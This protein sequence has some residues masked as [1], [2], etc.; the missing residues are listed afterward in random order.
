MQYSLFGRTGLTVSRL[1]LGT[2]TFGKQ[3]DEA[4]SFRIFDMAAEAGVNLIDTADMYP[5][6]VGFAERGRSEEFTGRWLKGKR[7]RFILATKAGG[8]MGPLAWDQGTSRKH[9]L[10]AVD[11][12]LRR[13]DVDYI[14]LYQLHM[15]DVAT[16]PDETIEA[17]DTIVRSGKARYVG[18][19]NF[20]AYRLARALGRQE[21]LRLARYV[22]VQPRYNLLFREIER[23]LLPLAAEEQLAVIPFNPLAGG[24]LTDRYQLQDSPE[25][26][27]FSAELGQFG[28]MYQERYWHQ[29][30]FE[31]IG[32]LRDVA[33]ETG[34]PLARL[35][36][37]WVLANPAITSVILGASRADQ[38]TDTLSAV[39]YRLPASVK[40]RFDEIT[41]DYR[42]G[43]AGK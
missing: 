1:T 21:M 18:V 29:R 36:I 23:E 38:L 28:A 43:D 35:A 37:A 39:D 20:L 26:G 14:D 27:R 17:L 41:I 22:S 33:A 25:T 10:D 34:E 11:A 32:K 2:G 15:D 7:D 9:L 24:L 19:S 16:S 12:S 30:E 5:A 31:T 4:E 8:G 13:L 42:R 6:G 40:E 3:T